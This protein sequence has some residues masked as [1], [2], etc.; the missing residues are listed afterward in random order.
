[1]VKSIL[2]V[3]KIN[4][5]TFP[6]SR[7][8]K[9]E[10]YETPSEIMFTVCPISI[11][12][13]PTRASSFKIS[14]TT[15]SGLAYTAPIVSG[16]GAGL[17]GQAENSNRASKAYPVNSF[18]IWS[19]K[20]W[21]VTTAIAKNA[22]ITTSKL[23]ATTVIEQ[24]NGLGGF[25]FG[26]TADNRPGY[27]EP[28][29]DTVNP[30]STGGIDVLGSATGTF[31][32]N[33]PFAIASGVDLSEYAWIGVYEEAQRGVFPYSN[34]QVAIG[35]TNFYI[36]HYHDMNGADPRNDDDPKFSLFIPVS[37]RTDTVTITATNLSGD[38]PPPT[39]TVTVYG[40][41]GE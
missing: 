7:P 40:I 3:P 2:I 27:I 9:S 23:A 4:L 20:L 14:T 10:G 25:R 24:L 12:F 5:V 17:I 15:I 41:K 1:M 37:G 22:T 11:V 26:Y 8:V 21:K 6:T 13:A 31:S 38:Y 19:N 36:T 29:A 35:N 33:L 39:G 34:I 16:A 28:G 30:F 32:Q 18:M